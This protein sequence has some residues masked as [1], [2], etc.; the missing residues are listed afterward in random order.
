MRTYTVGF[1]F[2]PDKQKVLLI[3]KNKPE[4]QKGLLNG[5]GGMCEK[6]ES[7]A[8]TM[9]REFNEE[10]IFYIAGWTQYLSLL[11]AKGDIVV[12][13]HNTASSEDMPYLT[14]H[15]IDEGDVDWYDIKDL[16]QLQVIPNL[17]W[18]IPMCFDPDHK[19]GVVI[20]HNY[21]D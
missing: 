4:W 13:F 9:I 20:T 7:P 8:Q 6:G 11:T 17:H 14:K 12:F 3:K 19:H 15:S 1:L 10:G 5:I 18:L 2:S 16:N 21:M